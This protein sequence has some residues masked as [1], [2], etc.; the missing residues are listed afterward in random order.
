MMNKLVYIIDYK[1]HQSEYLELCENISR[2]ELGCKGKCQMGKKVHQDEKKEQ[3]RQDVKPEK[4]N[5][6]FEGKFIISIATSATTSAKLYFQL[7]DCGLEI[8]SPRTLFR[9]PIV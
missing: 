6:F 8:K 5:E 2:P 9:P 7:N 1:L 3:Q 4:K